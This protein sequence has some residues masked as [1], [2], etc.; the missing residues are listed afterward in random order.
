MNSFRIWIPS[1]LVFMLHYTQAVSYRESP[2]LITINPPEIFDPTPFGYSHISVD[3][4][5]QVAT[6]AGQIAVNKSLSIVG[7]TLEEQLQE[8]E[9]N[10]KFAL[11]AIDADVKDIFK[12]NTYVVDFDSSKDLDIWTPTGIRL[13]S[14]PGV[15]MST[16]GLALEGLLA[17]I[18]IYVAVSEKF[19]R[20]ISCEQNKLITSLE[21]AKVNCDCSH[22]GI[23]AVSVDIHSE[24]RE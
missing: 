17:E 4:H 12:L 2:R 19:V 18:E 22:V 16:P 24:E 10:L 21:K 11:D 7:T 6:V 3:T 23:E 1:V 15:L 14:P 9:R 20:K 5:T 13:G 8:I